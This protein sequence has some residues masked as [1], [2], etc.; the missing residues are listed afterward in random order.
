MRAVAPLGHVHTVE[1]H[2]ER[3]KIARAEFAEHTI[4]DFVTVYNRDV[5]EKG[6]PEEIDHQGNAIK[7]PT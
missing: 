5:I 6:F 2:E 1:L 3:A 7:V 4:S